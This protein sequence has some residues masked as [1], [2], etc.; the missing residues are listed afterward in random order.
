M[1]VTNT[2]KAIMGLTQEIREQ[3]ASTKNNELQNEEN[4]REMIE[5]LSEIRDNLAGGGVSTPDLAPLDEKKGFGLNLSKFLKV[6]IAQVL[7]VLV[8]S[9][10]FIPA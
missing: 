3:N 9:I 5:L 4:R 7:G 6:P 1:S 2:S 8:A 10:A